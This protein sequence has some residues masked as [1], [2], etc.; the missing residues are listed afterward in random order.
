MA[1]KGMYS[2]T[3]FQ[4]SVAQL[5]EWSQSHPEFTPAGPPR[6]LAYNSPFMPFWMKYAEVQ[7]PVQATVR[8]SPPA[9]ER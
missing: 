8:E 7:I 1:R 6:V 4:A 3:N 5:R 9:S 2:K